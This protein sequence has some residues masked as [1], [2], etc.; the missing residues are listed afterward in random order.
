MKQFVILC[1]E[2]AMKGLQNVFTPLGLQFLEV[3]GIPQVEGQFLVLATP[4]H[5][6]EEKEE[7]IS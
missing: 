1:N 2:D 7:V 3:Q 4:N 6:V 5:P